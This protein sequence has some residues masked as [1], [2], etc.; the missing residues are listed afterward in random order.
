MSLHKKQKEIKRHCDCH[1]RGAVYTGNKASRRLYTLVSPRPKGRAR[2]KDLPRRKIPTLRI[3]SN[4][5]RLI[6]MTHYQ[7]LEVY[8]SARGSATCHRYFPRARVSLFLALCK[9]IGLAGW[10]FASKLQPRA[11]APHVQSLTMAHART[12]ATIVAGRSRSAW[13]Q[14]REVRKLAMCHRVIFSDW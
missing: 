2:M 8:F 10:L 6:S 7:T 4:A 9:I 1:P 13:T 3:T 12:R 5:T 11:D 14:R